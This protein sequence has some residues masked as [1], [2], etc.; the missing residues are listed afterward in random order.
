[1]GILWFLLFV[2][3]NNQNLNHFIMKKT[4]FFKIVLLSTILSLGFNAKAQKPKTNFHG[5]EVFSEVICVKFE[6]DPGVIQKMEAVFNSGN[7]I[8][9]TLKSTKEKVLEEIPGLTKM[10]RL[11]KNFSAVEMKRIF[12]PAGKFEK[13]H[14]EFGL[15]LWYEIKYKEGVDI[16]E[17]ISSYSDLSYIQLV[18]PRYVV[19]RTGTLP[20]GANDPYYSQ[21]WHYENSGSNGGTLDSDI[22]LEEAWTIET[23]N[24]NVIVAIEDGG[25]DVDHIDLIGNIWVNAGE[26]ANNGIDDDNNGYVDDVNG[27]N[28]VNNT[29]TIVADDHGTHVSGTIAAETNNGIGVSGIAGGTGNNDGARLMSCQVFTSNDADGFDEAFVYAADN[30]AVISQNSW[31]YTNAGVYD[32]SVLDAI[33]YFIANA[34]GANAAMD[35]GIVIVAAGNSSSSSAYYPGYYSPTLAV[36][37]V[38]NQDKISWYSNYGSW[39]DISAPGGETNSV[40]SRGV[41]STVANNDYDFYQGTSMACPHVS[42]VAAL[43]VSYNYGDITASELRDILV[44]NVDDIDYLNSGYAGQLG[45]GRLN[46]YLALS[47]GTV[48]V[49]DTASN[50]NP[51]DNSDGISI[52]SSLSWDAGSRAASHDVYFGTVNPP[53]F[54]GNQTSTTY[55]P[56][57]LSPNTTYYWRVDEVNSAGTTTGNVWSFTTNDGSVL[58]YASLPYST[59]FENG[60]IDEFW[61]L[62]TENSYGRLQVTSSNSPR[63]NYHLTSDVTTNGN[64]STNE[65]WLKV[66][67][68]GYEQVDLSFYWKEFGDEDNAEDGVFISDNA[69][70]TFTNIYSLTGGSSTYQQISIDLDEAASASGLSLTGNFVIKFQQRD[71]YSIATDGFAF[72]DISVTAGSEPS[73]TYPVTLEF[74]FDN[75]PEETSW[76]ITNSIGA[77]I[78]SGGTYGSEPDGSTKIINMNLSAECFNFTIYDSYGDG[79]CCS[80]GNGSYELS[81]GATVLASGGEFNS[82]ETTSFCVVETSQSEIAAQGI[83]NVIEGK[84]DL[85]IE[86][87]PNP[88]VNFMVIKAQITDQSVYTIMDLTGKTITKGN[89]A[90]QETYIDMSRFSAG[91]YFIDIT[92]DGESYTRK[93]VK[94]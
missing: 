49:P 3:L 90:N 31:G 5:K 59:G 27:Y 23:G 22:D 85:D 79:I 8:S 42:G 94:N 61:V 74:V 28:F 43:V 67:L 18:T 2:I 36:A 51:A 88:V 66:D 41:L 7:L 92:I 15:H 87:Y 72:D 6:N 29:G 10:N 19:E 70:A 33:D 62:E 44:D 55:V 30:G 93:V 16:Q 75:Y 4:T 26:I 91:V 47:S 89:L 80:Y 77:I 12:R 46:A 56:S 40:A 48:T 53:S 38:N 37:G 14:R 34:G 39:V 58:E 81:Q 11:N 57:A 83:S 25:V 76:E 65:A 54:I 52:S 32:Q 69:G 84:D 60:S 64:Y 78:E 9:G 17:V 68:S 21:Q 24:S 45:S 20:G 50:S 82:T 71:N 1:M 63:D 13:K 86:I 35:G 73:D